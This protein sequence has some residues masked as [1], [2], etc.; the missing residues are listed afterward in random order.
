MKTTKMMKTINR[1]IQEGK[2]DLTTADVKKYFG[3]PDDQLAE[4]FEY[5]GC[6]VQVEKDTFHV[7]LVRA[8]DEEEIA[9][10]ERMESFDTF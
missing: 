9:H 1:L 2:T 6:D 7:K 4:Q 3:K 8:F 5:L 10:E